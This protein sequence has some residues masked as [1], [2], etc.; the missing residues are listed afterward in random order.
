MLTNITITSTNITGTESLLIYNRHSQS[1]Q[2]EEKI[3]RVTPQ[4][5]LK[6]P[7]DQVS[8]NRQLSQ[9]ITYSMPKKI[10]TAPSDYKTL[11]ELII[12]M[13]NQQGMATKI[14]NGE[15][16][17]DFNSLTPE[18]AQK[19][20]SDDGYFGVDKTSERIVQFAIS[21]NGND[22]AKLKEIKAGIEKGFKMAAKA[23]GGTL[24]DISI[25]TYNRV[26]EKLDV[27]AKSFDSVQ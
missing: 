18:K 10:G 9:P 20:V 27:W 19:L 8:L 25:K 15:T 14:A 7:E 22:P 5:V 13:L 17:I 1:I 6:V 11:R 26:M 24:P 21:L 16:I 23:L 4:H 3:Q 2:S 12:N